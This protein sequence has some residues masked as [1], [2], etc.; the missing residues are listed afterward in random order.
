MPQVVQC[1]ECLST[2]TPGI[3]KRCQ[4]CGASLPSEFWIESI[5]PPDYDFHV[6]I[7]VVNGPDLKR[8]AI[9]DDQHV[10]PAAPDQRELTRW[11]FIEID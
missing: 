11:S 7:A 4:G 10:D 9:V 3:F 2:H 5:A 8:P 6:T 1:R